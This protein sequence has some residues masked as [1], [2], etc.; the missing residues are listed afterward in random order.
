MSVLLRPVGVARLDAA[1]IAAVDDTDQLRDVLAFPSHLRDALARVRQAGI[2]PLNAR[3][4]LVIAGMGGSAVG[5]RL[6][7]GVLAPTLRAPLVVS[8]GYTLPGWVGRETAVLCSSY[9]GGTEESLSAYEDATRRGAQRLVATTGG[10]LGR[11][12]QAD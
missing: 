4:G 11:R 7:L 6:A 10:S 1:T 2:S 12:A 8:D 3:G 9:S 5:G